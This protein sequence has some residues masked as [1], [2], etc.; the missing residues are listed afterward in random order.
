MVFLYQ[1]N[2]TEIQ[3]FV[4]Y[5]KEATQNNEMQL[6]LFQIDKCLICS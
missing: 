4:W 5:L 3:I 2:G 6:V 1:L